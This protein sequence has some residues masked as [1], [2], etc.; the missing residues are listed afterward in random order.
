MMVK[1][2]PLKV[3]VF[4]SKLIS[5][6]GIY[7]IFWVQKDVNLRLFPVSALKILPYRD[8]FFLQSENFIIY[9]EN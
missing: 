4:F 3:Q 6:D 7:A 1:K 8:V 9:A 2:I 5:S